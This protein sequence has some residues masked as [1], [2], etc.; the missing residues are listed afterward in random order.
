MA[1][2]VAKL[3]WAWLWTSNAAVL[4]FSLRYGRNFPTF[5]PCRSKFDIQHN[6]SCKKKWLCK[7]QKQRFTWSHCKNI[8]RSF[9]RYRDIADIITSIERRTSL[10]NKK[11]IKWSK[12]ST[13]ETCILGKC[14]CIFWY[15]GVWPKH[16][17]NERT[18]E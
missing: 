6:M 14:T 4:R 3:W 12:T 9:Q 16:P 13:L 7:H 18:R 5:R 10:K 1:H 11:M 15:N 8:I 2:N 17:C